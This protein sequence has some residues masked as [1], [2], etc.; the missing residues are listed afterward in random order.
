MNF[1]DDFSSI[2]IDNFKNQ[3]I[4]LFGLTSLQIYT[5][6]C[7]NPEL[8]EKPLRLDLNFTVGFEHVTELILLR[9]RMFPVVV[10]KFGV[11]GRIVWKV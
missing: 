9:E 8:V 6:T 5:G 4:L 1:Q 3:Y 10:N 7:H 2:P 11:V